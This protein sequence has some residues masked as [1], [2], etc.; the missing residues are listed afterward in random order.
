M[1]PTALRERPHRGLVYALSQDEL[2]ENLIAIEQRQALARRDTINE[3]LAECLG[4]IQGELGGAEDVFVRRN[5]HG[6]IVRCHTRES[7]I[8]AFAD[9]MPGD[10]DAIEAAVRARMTGVNG[11]IVS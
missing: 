1:P 3:A 4:K 11:E 6:E 9:L 5:Q 2:D 7:V 8:A 10:D